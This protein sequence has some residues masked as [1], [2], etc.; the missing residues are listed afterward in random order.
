MKE[1]CVKRFKD[2]SPEEALEAVYGLI[3]G[4]EPSNVGTTVSRSLCPLS[5]WSCHGPLHPKGYT[6]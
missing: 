2:K 3:E 6:C 5:T 4:K 1:I